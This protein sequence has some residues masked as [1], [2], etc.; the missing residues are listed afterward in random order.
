MSVGNLTYKSYYC[1][2]CQK[3]ALHVKN[4]SE[5]GMGDIIMMVISCGVWV[6]LRAMA[7]IVFHKWRCGVCGTKK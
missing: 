7:D 4:A 3:I 6:I 1:R 5:W 2:H